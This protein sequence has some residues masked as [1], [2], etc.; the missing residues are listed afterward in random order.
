MASQI[1][2]VQSNLIDYLSTEQV[3]VPQNDQAVF[4]KEERVSAW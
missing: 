3:I 2:Q 1:D 4:L